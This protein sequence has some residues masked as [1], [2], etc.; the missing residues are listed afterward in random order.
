M[1]SDTK[2]VLVIHEGNAS[3]EQCLKYQTIFRAL[4]KQDV[5]GVRD[6]YVCDSILDLPPVVEMNIREF[7]VQNGADIQ[8]LL[9]AS[10]NQED[11]G[12]WVASSLRKIFKFCYITGGYNNV[13]STDLNAGPYHAIEYKPKHVL[14]FPAKENVTYAIKWVI[15]ALKNR[16][17]WEALGQ[18]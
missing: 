1:I 8:S 10:E 18:D 12:E 6:S 5:I 11:F 14:Y 3:F 17:A 2:N 15:E 7:I 16:K 9:I 4:K 13:H